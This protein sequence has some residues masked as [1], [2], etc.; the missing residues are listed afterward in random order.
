MLS[1]PSSNKYDPVFNVFHKDGFHI[2]DVL[3]VHGDGYILHL[4]YIQG[5]LAIVSLQLHPLPHQPH[6]KFGSPT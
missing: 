1:L 6:H 2:Y 3:R 4:V 5:N